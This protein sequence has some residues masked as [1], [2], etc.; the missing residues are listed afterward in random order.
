MDLSSFFLNKNSDI[1]AYKILEDRPTL[2]DLVLFLDQ[3]AYHSSLSDYPVV[4][5]LQLL[6]PQLYIIK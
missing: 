2:S 4:L 6:C 1:V 5:L 3:S